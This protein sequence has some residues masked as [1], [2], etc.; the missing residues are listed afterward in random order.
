MAKF[1][2]LIAMFPSIV[3]GRSTDQPQIPLQHES[4]PESTLQLGEQLVC[5][6]IKVSTYFNHMYMKTN[7]NIHHLN[8]EMD[9]S[10][11]DIFGS[12]YVA[13]PQLSIIQKNTVLETYNVNDIFNMMNVYNNLYD[14]AFVEFEFSNC[15]TRVELINNIRKTIT[16]Y[17]DKLYPDNI[18]FVFDTF[19]YK[20]NDE[21][22]DV[23]V[24]FNDVECILKLC[25]NDCKKYIYNPEEQTCIYSLNL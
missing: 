19:D 23:R 3:K 22:R 24:C 21:K 17:I 7:A 12:K 25:N 4:I 9:Y 6:T 13:T 16:T 15:I 1:I 18:P 14:D 10:I 8:M 2:I 5:K 11:A 20:E